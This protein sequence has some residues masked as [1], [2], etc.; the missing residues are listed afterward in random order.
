MVRTEM[1]RKINV[2]ENRQKKAYCKSVGWADRVVYNGAF[3]AW[4]PPQSKWTLL[5]VELLFIN[6]ILDLKKIQQI[7][8]K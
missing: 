1:Q 6:F 7:F 5:I 2:Q 3:Y 8:Q 4:Q